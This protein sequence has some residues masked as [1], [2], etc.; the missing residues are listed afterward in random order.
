MPPDVVDRI[1]KSLTSH[2]A[3]NSTTLRTLSKCELGALSLANC[4]GVSDE[5]LASFGS[6]T[7]VCSGSRNRAR[8]LTDDE[9]MKQR[10]RSASSPTVNS[11][12]AGNYNTGCVSS[13][14]LR[15]IHPTQFVV[16]STAGSASI[17][18]DLDDYD[19]LNT[20]DYAS[21]H[22]QSMP[23]LPRCNEEETV[24][25]K[26][27]MFGYAGSDESRS[28]SSFHSAV[29]RPS[30]PLL[31]SVLPP[32]EFFSLKYSSP[33]PSS[34]L[35][36]YPMRGA[37]LP[38]LP[39][40]RQRPSPFS[41]ANNALSNEMHDDEMSYTDSTVST[42]ALLDL[43]GSQ[44]LTD[45][46]LLQL[47]HTPLSSLEIVKLDNCH[48]ITGRGL[49]AFSR[50]HRLHT[51][52]LANCRRLTDE[53]VVNVSHLSTSLT[54]LNL[55]G[56][57]C[58]TDR[59]L[60]ALSGLVELR[61]LNLDQCDL[62]TDEGLTS[63]EDLINIEEL[64]LGWCRLISDDGLEILAN[65]PNRS[66][67]L[68]TL[69]LARC[70]ITDDG[71]EHLEKLERL[72]HLDLNGCVNIGS[73]ELGET[74]GK[75][76]HLTSLDVSYCPGI[77]RSSWQGKINALK[78]LE[79]C[80]AGVQDNH[81]SRLRSLPNLEEL[82]LDSCIISDWGIAHLIDNEV[83]PNLTTLDLADTDI[84][85][86]AM[87][88]IAQFEN[89]RHLSLFYC[90]IT[91]RGLRHLASMKKLE[92]LN[93]DSRDIGDDG[94]KYLRNLPLTSLDLFSSRVTDLG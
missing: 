51:L 45:R 20:S 82:N 88:K 52:S 34:S 16:P 21:N 84:S 33:A 43:R 59:S 35:W 69:R 6:T 40:P 94:L 28:T 42:L 32:P 80:Y 7:S 67:V 70:S 56:C 60:D 12:T 27:T 92:V 8:T 17:M 46:G 9:E 78:S 3:L 37:P 81:L 44:R 39:L 77:L 55:D 10:L 36:L 25:K 83:M 73:A 29:S 26:T 54:A 74:L 38:S 13:P 72:E 66:Q 1:V 76:I 24:G 5:W 61:K 53:A 93:L 49:L 65:Q 68:R 41:D 86:A 87:E 19:E 48:G 58:L 90:N 47:S 63:L 85:N 11:S 64:S 18:M 31:P 22:L 14:P 57:R 91:N 71:L 62:I 89:M 50:S 30:S 4:R 2:A 23:L 15:D 79:L 75:L